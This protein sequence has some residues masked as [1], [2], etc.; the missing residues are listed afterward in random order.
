MPR[1]MSSVSALTADGAAVALGDAL[2]AD[3]GLR[4]GGLSSHALRHDGVEFGEARPRLDQQQRELELEQELGGPALRRIG[5]RGA[6]MSGDRREGCGDSRTVV[7]AFGDARQ[8]IVEPALRRV[9]ALLEAGEQAAL[10]IADRRRRLGRERSRAGSASASPSRSDAAE[11]SSDAAPSGAALVGDRRARLQEVLDGVQD[12]QEAARIL[13]GAKLSSVS[14]ITSSPRT[15]GSAGRSSRAPCIC[16]ADRPSPGWGENSTASPRGPEARRA[17]TRPCMCAR[18]GLLRERIVDEQPPV[19][20]TVAKAG[21]RRAAGPE[22]VVDGAVVVGDLERRR[23]AEAERPGREPAGGDADAGPQILLREDRPRIGHA[24]PGRAAARRGSRRRRRRR[25]AAPPRRESA[26]KAASAPVLSSLASRPQFE[27]PPG[28]TAMFSP[29]ARRPRSPC[30]RPARRHAEPREGERV[31]AVIGIGRGLGRRARRCA[32]CLT[33][34]A[35][36][37]TRARPWLDREAGAAQRLRER[38][39]QP[40]RDSRRPRASPLASGQRQ[41]S[42]P[43]AARRFAATA[44]S[45]RSP[46]ANQESR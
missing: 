11:G 3:V 7:P 30:R 12:H 9:E 39:A 23:Q 19:A 41:T 32:A 25:R 6:G 24:E 29:R 21:E 2:E 1:G 20:V 34:C 36:G 44:T 4:V 28:R 40:R 27:K 8:P 18:E 31:V 13:A 16:A 26:R 42:R 5:P 33:G 38:P 14:R 46:F 37:R 35:S 10:E 17:A 22:L 15:A 45:R 43:A